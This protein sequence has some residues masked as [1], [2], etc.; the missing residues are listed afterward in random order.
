M[1][2][3]CHS[4]KTHSHIPC[5]SS[6]HLRYASFS[7]S[8]NKTVI[9]IYAG[10]SFEWDN[11]AQEC[12]ALHARATL[13]QLVRISPQRKPLPEHYIV[14]GI[15]CASDKLRIIAHFP[16]KVEGEDEG[17][18]EFAQ[19]MV[20]EHWISIMELPPGKSL[21]REHVDDDAIIDR[22][23]ISVALFTIRYHIRHLKETFRDNELCIS[24]AT[25]YAPSLSCFTPSFYNSIFQC[26][27]TPE[28]CG[29]V[30]HSY[31]CYI[32]LPTLL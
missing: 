18:W 23:R 30:S 16:L 21:L 3:W 10:A 24:R 27:C 8:V 22:W 7:D 9:L 2:G 32:S 26:Y 12:F 5:I 11:V 17:Q 20:A 14:Y 31:A 19:V 1:C 28:R 25:V 6:G 29:H 4:R 15:H 13:I